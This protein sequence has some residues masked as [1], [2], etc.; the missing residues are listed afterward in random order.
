MKNALGSARLPLSLAV[1]IIWA[2]IT[3]LGGM[4][5]SGGQKQSL[6]EGLSKGPLWNVV[7]AFIFLVLV[8]V[9]AGWRD[10]KFGAPNPMSSLRIMWFPALYVIAFL[11]MAGLLGLPP[12]NLMLLILLSTAFV[13]LSE[14]TMFR[15]ILFQALRTRVKLWPAMIWTSVLF[16]SVH[17]LNALTTGELLNALLQAFT[18]TLSGFA[19]IAILVRTGSIWPAI[20]YHALWDFGTFAI[21]ASSAAQGPA[22]GGE[23]G[24]GAFLLP[25]LLVL[26]NFLYGV[27]LLRNVRNDDVLSR[28]KPFAQ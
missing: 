3:I 25:V 26:P 2:A 10:L 4:L 11:S 8:I 1:Y 14:E 20:I 12:L 13:G 22:S 17:I 21:S 23:V 7:A 19:F 15:G 6:I 9:V 28:D 24:G 27:Y 18:A 16:G 5:L